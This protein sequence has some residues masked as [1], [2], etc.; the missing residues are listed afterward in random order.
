MIA[1]IFPEAH[2]YKAASLNSLGNVLTRVGRHAE[3][4]SLLVESVA[5]HRLVFPPA[6]PNIAFPLTGLGRLYLEQG[7]FEEAEPVLREAY[8]ARSGGL[9]EGHWEV[10]P[11][12]L[13]LA[14]ALDAL[15]REEEAEAFFEE[16]HATLLANFGPD[17]A[18][19]SEAREAFREHL[20]R[21][22]MTERAARLDS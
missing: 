14:R 9:P 22:G 1:E 10:A 16:S 11:S 7:R 6:H 3:A 4:E 8:E 2:P 18:R 19:T 15:G 12:A 17:D 20:L 5:M 13:E 21:R